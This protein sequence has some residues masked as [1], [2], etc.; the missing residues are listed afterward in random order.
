[1]ASRRVPITAAYGDGIGPEIMEATLHILNEGG[2]EIEKETIEI[3]EKVCLR[4]ISAAIKPSSWESLRRTKVFLKAPITMPQGAVQSLNVT[5][6]K[7]LGLYANVRPCEAVVDRLGK[8]PETLK[9]ASYSRSLQEGY[10]HKSTERA[11]AKKE[12]VSVDVFID[13][14]GRNANEFGKNEEALRGD[15]LKLSVINNHGV[16]VYPDGFAETFCSDHWRCGFTA[17]ETGKAVTHDQIVKLP[18]RFD[19]S[20]LDFIQIENYDF[21]GQKGFSA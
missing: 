18:E 13:W 14:P 1:M 2:A 16:K 7:T 17:G 5:T 19:Q 8:T 3:G 21:D 15:G 9:P 4:E 10:T 11:R 20:G 6:R 12:L